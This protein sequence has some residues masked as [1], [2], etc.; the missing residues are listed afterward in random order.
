MIG[1]ILYFGGGVIF[2]TVIL[3]LFYNDDLPLVTGT[4]CALMSCVCA[5]LLL[6]FVDRPVQLDP[7]LPMFALLLLPCV[8]AGTAV[9]SHAMLYLSRTSVLLLVSAVALVM[10][11]LITFQRQ[12]FSW[13]AVGEASHS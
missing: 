2:V 4:G 1:G 13:A 6:T 11:V 9:S 10:G 5:G 7:E 12:I 3:F 8:V